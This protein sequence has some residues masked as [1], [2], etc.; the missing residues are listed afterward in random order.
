[1][2]TALTLK[3]SDFYFGRTLDLDRSYAEEVVVVPRNMPLEF[4]K[5]PELKE[6]YALI[7]MAALVGG[8]PLF[9]DGANEC[10]LSAAGLNFPNNAYYFEEKS[11]KDNIAPFEFIS[12]IL[13]QCKNLGEAKILLEK[14]NIVSI[15]FSESL[16][17]S[18][19]HWIIADKNGSL[20]V[21]SISDGLHIYENPVGVM[22]NNPPFPYQLENLEKYKGLRTDNGENSLPESLAKTHFCQGLGAVGLPGDVSSM[23]RFVRAVFG[24]T[25]S[26][27]APDENSSVSQFFHILG[28]VSMTRGICKVPS[29][30]YDITVYT[31][32]INTDKG[33]Y[34]YTTYDNQRIGCV[35][36]HKCDLD[37]LKM[38][39]FPLIK[40][41][42]IYN[43]N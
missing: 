2:C 16:P 19:L 13:G 39:R 34:Y 25:N 42:Q 21:E 41:S 23:S 35:N 6:H 3:T 7:G 29:G 17:N 40:E 20:V 37:G 22:T 30:H 36:M 15:S 31:S 38:F 4:K 18:P 32:C 9:Y 33:L 1:M 28:D 8:V 5:M 10:G 26:M 27:C 11:G 43:Q 24:K 12:W 14:I